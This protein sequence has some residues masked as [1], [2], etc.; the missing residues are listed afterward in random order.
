MATRTIADAGGNYSDNAT[1]VEGAAPTAADDV[2]ATATS[3]DL[4]INATAAARS[5]DF[6]DY[7]GTLTHTAAVVWTIGTTS[8][9]GS[10]ALKLV[11][12]MT[13]NFGAA[14]T[15]QFSDQSGDQLGITT[16]GKSLGKVT[17]NSGVG[18]YLLLDALTCSG[19]LT[20]SRATVNT[21]GQAVTL[22]SWVCSGS[23][24]RAVTLGASTVTITAGSGAAWNFTGSSLTLDAGTSTIVFTGAP[25]TF[26]GGDRTYNNLTFTGAGPYTITG[27][28]TFAAL[29]AV[30]TPT[31]AART[32]TLPASA[33]T[34]ATTP[35]LAGRPGGALTFKSSSAGTA[36]TVSVAAGTVRLNHCSVQ[37]ITGAGG[38]TFEAYDSLNVSGNT[39]ITFKVPET[40]LLT[41]VG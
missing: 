31:Q 37:D 4:T 28:N 22:S 38:A 10:T 8:A 11:P 5:V 41:G 13:A 21:N 16:A 29:T 18:N 23:N 9:N 36:A 17:F 20:Q 19:V 1:W 27:A 32:L 26:A 34:T 39:D 7:V 30:S 6:T 12:G 35:S 2:V 14:G 33:T 3:G 25:Q 24:A 15:V 40:A